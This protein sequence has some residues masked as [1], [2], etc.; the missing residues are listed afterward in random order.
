MQSARRHICHSLVVG[1]AIVN[2]VVMN[3]DW[4]AACVWLCLKAH[5]APRAHVDG[6]KVTENS[7]AK[8]MKMVVSYTEDGWT[9]R[10]HSREA[11]GYAHASVRGLAH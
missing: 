3:Q 4:Q 8:V 1:N 2:Q 9:R 6:T 11:P 5:V 7:K 10:W